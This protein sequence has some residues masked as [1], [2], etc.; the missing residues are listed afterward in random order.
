LFDAHGQPR[1]VLAEFRRRRA[2]MNP[3]KVP[4]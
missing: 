1:P 3:S 2:G 4:A